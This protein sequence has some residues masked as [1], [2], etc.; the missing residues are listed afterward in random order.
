MSLCNLLSE[1][2]FDKYFY[3]RKKIK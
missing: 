3:R 1:E 2:L